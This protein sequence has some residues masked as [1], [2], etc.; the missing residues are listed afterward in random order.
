V[1]EK[2]TPDEE[3]DVR[4]LAKPDK[5]PRIFARFRRLA[6]GESLVVIDD[7]DPRELRDEFAAELTG[8]YRW[9]YLAR[10][11]RNWRIVITKTT[12]T[13]LPRVL[14]NTREIQAETDAAGAIW[15]LSAPD[16]D[17][18]SNVIALPSGQ[19][20]DTHYGPDLDVLLHVIEG[21]GRLTGEANVI[22]LVPGVLVWL[23]RRSQRQITAGPLGLRYLTVHRRRQSLVLEPPTRG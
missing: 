17:L 22:E 14:T 18:D 21:S 8:S 20:I 4:P 11:P 15:K 19:A 16:R 3:L 5:H 13:P 10:E 6:V 7:H 1:A 12:S 2:A 9:E 23:P